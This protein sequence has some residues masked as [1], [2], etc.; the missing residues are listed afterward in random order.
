M[1]RSGKS[2]CFALLERFYDLEPTDGEILLDGKPLR[3]YNIRTLRK[4]FGQV[5]QEPRLF[6][7][8]IRNNVLYG[9]RDEYM[10][11]LDNKDTKTLDEVQQQYNDIEQAAQSDRDETDQ[12]INACLQAANASSFIETL[13]KKLDTPVGEQGKGQLSGGQKQRVAIARAL[14]RDAPIMLLDEAT[15]A[16]DSESEKLVQDALNRIMEERTTL[17]IAHRLSTIQDA[18]LIIVMDKGLIVE[19]GTHQELLELDKVYAELCREQSMAT[20]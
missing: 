19:R 8:S 20:A 12:R 5:E 1:H 3:E 10:S 14:L 16:L 15:S 4:I 17:V 11:M 6:G 18:D 13:P 7:T 9:T 2:T